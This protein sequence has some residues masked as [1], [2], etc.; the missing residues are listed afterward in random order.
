MEDVCTVFEPMAIQC[1]M[2]EA[3]KFV[4]SQICIAV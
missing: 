4:W 2:Y 1:W 3:Q